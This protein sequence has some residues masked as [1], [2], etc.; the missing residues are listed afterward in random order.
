MGL[1]AQ[2]R[3]CGR[4]DLAIEILAEPVQH[5][6]KRVPR[7]LLVGVD[8]SGSAVQW[9]TGWP[10]TR[11]AMAVMDADHRDALF[12]QH[13]NHVPLARELAADAEV[14]WGGPHT[15]DAVVTELDSRG[16]TSQDVGF[17]GPLSARA[18]RQLTQA[19]NNRFP[20]WS[21]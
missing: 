18:H 3:A 17:V 11:E 2:L 10:V 14:A 12:L 20:S 6:A 16:A 15:V 21:Q 7:V 9:I 8:R 4:D 5:L 13:F 19:G 1:E